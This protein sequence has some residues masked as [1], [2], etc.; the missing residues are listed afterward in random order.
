MDT[1]NTLD[2]PNPIHPVA[3][4]SVSEGGN[5]ALDVPSKSVVV[6]EVLAPLYTRAFFPGFEIFFTFPGTAGAARVGDPLESSSA[7]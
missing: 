4:Q 3:F 7:T 2:A 6:A 5:F 1:H